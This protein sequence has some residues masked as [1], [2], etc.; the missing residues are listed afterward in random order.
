MKGERKR[1]EKRRGQSVLTNLALNR[2]SIH[3]LDNT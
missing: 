3:M 2:A 1:K